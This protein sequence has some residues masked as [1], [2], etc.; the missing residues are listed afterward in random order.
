MEQWRLA[1]TVAKRSSAGFPYLY[2]IECSET[3]QYLFSVPVSLPASS[4]LAAEADCGKKRKKK[5]E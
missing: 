5:G 4:R 3:R 1:T 2:T